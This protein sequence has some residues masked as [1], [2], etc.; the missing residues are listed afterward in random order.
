M[1]QLRARGKDYDFT[2][3]EQRLQPL[4]FRLVFVTRSPES[5]AA[6]RQERLKIS[7]NPQQYDNLQ[8]FVEEQE[9]MRRLV[10]ESRLPVLTLDISDNN[11]PAAVERIADWMEST[12]GLWMD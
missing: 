8:I 6:A 4:G 2:W 7:G 9:L 3:L 1:Y 10:R 5:F 12:G 11:V